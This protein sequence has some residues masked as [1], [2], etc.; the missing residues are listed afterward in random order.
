M[1][2]AAVLVPSVLAALLTLVGM[3]QLLGNPKQ[4]EALDAVRIDR[5]W[6][7]VIAWTQLAGA[8]GLLVGIAWHSI[9]LAAA[10]G[11]VLMFAIAI[12]IHLR[13]RNVNVLPALAMLM[14]GVAALVLFLEA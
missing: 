4:L 10:T 9:G 3:G 8:L 13:A 2:L 14:L 7:P 12:G 1:Q 5:R 11:V 6:V